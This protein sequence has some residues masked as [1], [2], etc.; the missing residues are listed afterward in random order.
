MGS[1]KVV[2]NSYVFTKT[3]QMASTRAVFTS[4]YHTKHIN[5][6][7]NSSASCVVNYSHLSS[8]SGNMEPFEGDPST[9]VHMTSLSTKPQQSS[10]GNFQHKYLPELLVHVYS[11][12]FIVKSVSCCCMRGSWLF[13][14]S[15]TNIVCPSYIEQQW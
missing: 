6:W 15:V 9:C 7:P 5:P 11:Y 14:N 12:H 3:S 2:G 8:C 13:S 1:H 10:L 4:T